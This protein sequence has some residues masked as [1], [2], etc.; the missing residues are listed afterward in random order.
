MP[1]RVHKNPSP[2][3]DDYL[4]ALQKYTG[5]LRVPGLDLSSPPLPFDD[6]FVEPSLRL[7]MQLEGLPRPD[8]DGAA[9]A[10]TEA[11]AAILAREQA[12]VLLGEPGEGKSTLLR[13]Y[14]SRMAGDGN[15]S[16][17]P[18]LIELG[19]NPERIQSASVDF[20]WLYERLPELLKTVLGADGWI[21]VCT[22]VRSEGASVLLDGFDELSLNARRQ[23]GE[24]IGAL[25]GNQ[26]VLASRPPAYSGAPLAGFKP[27]KLVPLALDQSDSLVHSVVAALARQY[28]ALDY[29]EPMRRLIE[30]CRGPGRAMA[31]NPLL[32]SFMCLTAISRFA[33]NSDLLLPVRPVPLIRDCVEALVVWQRE[34]KASSTWPEA[35][36]GAEVIRILAPL[37]LTTLQEPDGAGVIK[38]ATVEALS[39][40]DKGTFFTHLISGYFVVRNNANYRFPIETLRE[41]FAA[42]ALAATSD[43]FAA[44]RAHLHDPRWERV[45]L[46]TAGSL[47]R[48]DAAKIDL[49][50]PTL[51]WLFVTLGSPFLKLAAGVAG[52]A[53]E[54]ASKL[55][56]KAVDEAL[57]GAGEFG[58]SRQSVLERWLAGS[59]RSTE[60]FVTSI[61]R[62]RSPYEK[63]L[64]RDWWLAVRCLMHS[65][66][67]PEELGNR[68]TDVTPR[69]PEEKALLL[70]H[71]QATA[72]NREIRDAMPPQGDKE[73]AL[74]NAPDQAPPGLSES[75]IERL[76]QKTHDDDHDVRANAATA[77]G[78]AISVPSVLERL[79]QLTRDR[80]TTVAWIATGAM[81]GVASDGRVREHLLSLTRNHPLVAGAAVR[82]LTGEISEPRVRERMLELAGPQPQIDWEDQIFVRRPAVEALMQLAPEAAVQSVMVKLLAD[83]ERI[84]RRAAVQWLYWA[85][86]SDPALSAQLL[87]FSWA[88]SSL[89]RGAVT[90]VL[91]SVA[92]DPLVRVRLLQLTNDPDPSVCCDAAVALELGAFDPAVRGR[93]LELTRP[94]MY[95]AVRTAAARAL[96]GVPGSAVTREMLQRVARIAKRNDSVLDALDRLVQGYEEAR[97]SR[98]NRK[99]INL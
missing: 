31:A 44:V 68:L 94:I 19:R 22:V 28:G 56:G 6:I 80:H 71:L 23:V 52:V 1:K 35:L 3:V 53:I 82:A 48:V 42:R 2:L 78:K 98:G 40:A 96:R 76:L 9:P 13:R 79:I 73:P 29:R 63:L 8:A 45:I 88:R 87:E 39:S 12:L 51:C 38:E 92:A 24:L 62:H 69:N 99:R 55:I 47:E 33:S 95:P 10:D 74:S 5:E 59:R 49:A 46:Y 36:T 15:R 25:A 37:A 86:P 4:R 7:A 57:K 77:L 93:L 66:A 75:E 41:F 65:P 97:R 64:Q 11:A 67:F 21:E 18:L 83:H 32:L 72:G 50:I 16:R 90:A 26:V 54:P 85:A 89:L 27:Y 30:I 60:Y 84:L 17:L 91:G 34:H 61:F 70:S 81:R 43:P 58:Q 20:A 14:A